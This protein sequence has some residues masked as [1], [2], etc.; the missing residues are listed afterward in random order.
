MLLKYEMQDYQALN[1]DGIVYILTLR[2]SILFGIYKYTKRAKAL[3]PYHLNGS[4]VHEP[5][6]NKWVTPK[7]AKEIVNQRNKK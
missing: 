3:V 2:I 7:K 1:V 5:L 4:E 6:M